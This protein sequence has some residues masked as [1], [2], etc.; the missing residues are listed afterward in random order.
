M[1]IRRLL[2]LTFL[3]IF[4]LAC[5]QQENENRVD[6]SQSPTSLAVSDK[7]F[8]LQ[9]QTQAFELT[10]FEILDVSESE[11]DKTP[12]LAISFSV[13][14]N[15][16]VDFNQFLNVYDKNDA[17]IAG[18]WIL[19]D[20]RTRLFFLNIEGSQTYKVSIDKNITSITN[21]RLA[22]N[23]E[24]LVKTARLT[25]SVRFLNR[26]SILPTDLTRGLAVESVNVKEV[27]VN[28]HRVDEKKIAQVM[29]DRLS[30]YSY[31]VRGIPEYAE[32]AYSARYQLD[33]VANKR[34]TTNLPIHQVPELQQPGLYLAVMKPAGTYPYEHQVT[35]F[36]ISN[37]A[38]H[39]RTF[40][41]NIEIHAL[42]ISD[43]KPLSQVELQVLSRK[44]NVLARGTT[45]KEGNHRIA[46]F[47]NDAVIIAKQKDHFALITMSAPAL[48]LSE[49][50]SETRNFK[51]QEVFLYGPRDLYRPG[52]NIE[53]NA[54]LRDFD[55]QQTASVPL[56]V[57]ILRPDNRV[58]KE[59]TWH[60][61]LDGFYQQEFAI[62]R[63]EPTGTW[64]F[65]VNHP[66]GDV[67]E[68]NFS[69]EEFMP[70][71]MRLEL[72]SSTDGFLGKKDSV[73]ISGQ[74]DYLYGAPASG[75][76]IAANLKLQANHFPHPTLKEYFFGNYQKQQTDNSIE[77]DD[78]NLDE[79]GAVIWALPNLWSNKKFPT[80][81]I[82]EASLFESGG[83]PV[84]RRI[85]HT[86]WPGD[87]YFGVRKL[88][89][90]KLAKPYKDADFEIILADKSGDLHSLDEFEVSLV[91]EDRRYY[92]RAQGN[93][94]GYSQNYKSKKVYSRIINET[95]KKHS[96]SLPVEYG[97]YRLEIRDKHGALKNSYQFFAGWS[98]DES[99]EGAVAG[100]RPDLVRIAFDQES[101]QA[102]QTAKVKLTSPHLG[103]ALL[104]VEGNK[105]LWEKQVNLS[106]LETTI[107]VPVANDW[108]RHDL[109]F[110]AMVVSQ[111]TKKQSDIQLPKRALGIAPFRLSRNERKLG[112]SIIAPEITEP[113]QSISVKVKLDKPVSADAYVTLAAV[114]TGVL[115]LSDYQTPDP[116]QWFYG[117]RKYSAHIRDS[118]S[119][120]IKNREGNLAVLKFGGDAELAR[121][122][123][124][125]NTDVQIVSLFSDV[126]KFDQNGEAD[127]KLDLPRFNGELRLMALVFSGDEF[128]HHEATMKVRA[129]IVAEISK[130]RFLATND[131]SMFG[132]DLQ[133]MSGEPKQLIAK[134]IIGGALEKQTPSITADLKDGEKISEIINVKAIGVG[135]GSIRLELQDAQ[136]NTLLTRDWILGVRPAYPAEFSRQRKV[137]QKDVSFSL[138]PEWLEP[139]DPKTFQAR[140]EYSSV[141]PL[142]SESHLEHLFRY[143]YGCLEQTSSRAWP[144]LKF[145]ASKGDIKLDKQA[146]KV[147]LERGKHI[148]AAIQRISGM[149]RHDGSF[150]LWSNT[151]A[152]NHWLTVYALDFL[153]SAKS[154][155]FAV[156]GSV[157]QKAQDK[158]Q[159]Y[160]KRLN[161]GY[162]E[163]NHYSQDAQHYALSFRAYAVS[164]MANYNQTNLSQARQ[165]NNKY[166]DKAKSG[167]PLAHLATA[168]EKLGDTKTAQSLWNKALSFKDYQLGYGGDY[169]SE[170][171]D[172]AW[173][174]LLAS[175]S[176]LKLNYQE[177][178]F[179][180]NNAL[181]KKRWFSTQERF[182]LYQLA[183]RL[184][185]SQTK[186]WQVSVSSNNEEVES[187]THAGKLARLLPAKAFTQQQSSK[188]TQGESLFVDLQMV[189][190]PKNSPPALS[191]GISVKKRFYNLQGQ[192][193]NLAQVKAGDYVLVRLDTT[194]SER[195][196]DALMVDLLPAG[197]ELENPGLEYA[198][199]YSEVM[200]EGYPVYQ[201]S[202]NARV[203]HQEFRDD[204]FVAAVSLEKRQ[205]TTLFYL[206]RAVT[207]GTYTIPPAQVE[208][209]YRPQ[210]RALGESFAP[211]KVLAR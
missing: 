173:V 76:R 21:K 42:N 50:L 194:A 46:R 120:L 63:S 98:W 116:H 107:E 138:K 57:S 176:K 67:F 196:P 147:L 193:L 69:V 139:F 25:D 55:G 91:R 51:K 33:Y 47:D 197:F 26:G 164:L 109:Y 199:D 151:S 110:S 65:R 181:L 177:L 207:A 74:G 183:K 73:V 16:Q 205:W 62:S 111:V 208:D 64:I 93:A 130:P 75:N 184:E 29:R 145:N 72:S 3:S 82:F 30:G 37:L 160:I 150:G 36:Y 88:F 11:Y 179:Y 134:F 172:L 114:D 83:R 190:Y 162:S 202:N 5:T 71:T 156:P 101:Y 119:D 23:H 61:K 95:G 100:A 85:R 34:Q 117:Q 104:R 78:K 142:N 20:S 191:Q 32:L 168:F 140:I 157:I 189:G 112:V 106:D 66:G 19:N 7:P 115:S 102:N 87:K 68:Y 188:L 209:M 9:A 165:I 24:S 44:G 53:I 96:V 124:Q 192:A 127:V 48:D 18:G 60:P 141:P 169:G 149:Q 79:S 123:E 175:D 204:R 201:W 6:K 180:I 43:G 22:N 17:P 129:P 77:L 153:L 49:Q 86:V 128:G 195:M 186:S 135:D 159:Q 54:L 41:K 70:E 185:R 146:Q 133:N 210:L 40:D 132:F 59:F 143:P 187:I 126:I 92:W 137:L 206:M 121:G 52:E 152:E 103:R 166:A 148:D 155:G 97:T 174:M 163:R 12:A 108:N 2:G 13:P 118:F 154:S 4:L 15:I 38:L 84:T 125:P 90:E 203:E 122:G 182:A 35:S 178:I 144:L 105:V 28:F 94:W 31:Y 171:R 158:V 14:I 56:G 161:I 200:I 45:D 136:Q 198:Y 10:N 8:D 167:L 1:N 58:A 211:V 89:S 80:Q 131:L 170:I 99:G 81:V 39:T 27:D 113:A